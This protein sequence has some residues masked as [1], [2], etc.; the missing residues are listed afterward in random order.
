[1]K[2]T[3]LVV[4]P[5][6]ALLVT[7]SAAGDYTVAPNWLKLPDGRMQ[8]GNQH[9]DL[10]VSSAGEVYVSVQDP[11]A[12]LQVFSARGAVP[13]QRAR[14]A[15]RLSRLRDPQGRR[16]ASSSTA[17]RCAARRSSR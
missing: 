11:A 16:T 5:V 12:G 10:A 13:A 4:I 9:G 17:P 7:A 8:L 15:E 3:R 14:R 6:I 2:K 1:M